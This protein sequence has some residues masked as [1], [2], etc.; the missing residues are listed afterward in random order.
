MAPHRMDFVIQ[1]HVKVR[2]RDGAEFVFNECLNTFVG[3]C[4]DEHIEWCEKFVIKVL[5]N[6]F[7][8]NKQKMM[9]DAVRKEVL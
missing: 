7:Y 1:Q 4:T 8:N 6:D 9:F 3:K 2:A 5:V